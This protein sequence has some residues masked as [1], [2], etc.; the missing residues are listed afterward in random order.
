MERIRQSLVA[1]AVGSRGQDHRELAVALG[2]R[3]LDH[4]E[5]NNHEEEGQIRYEKIE[6]GMERVFHPTLSGIPIPSLR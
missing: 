5:T 2:S 4:R 3:G 6:D 1:D